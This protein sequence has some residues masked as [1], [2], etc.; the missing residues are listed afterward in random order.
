MNPDVL[1][2]MML[3]GLTTSLARSSAQFNGLLESDAE[4]VRVPG[5]SDLWLAAT[6]DAVVEEI[7]TGLYADP[8]LLG[9][10]TVMV[11]LSDLAAVGAAP[12]GVL[13]A[14]TLK[15][16]MT[17][18][19]IQEMQ[20]GIDG[21]VRACGTHVLGGDTSI[22]D[23]QE[24]CGTALGFVRAEKPL[25]RCGCCAGDIL[26]LSGPAGTGNAFALA[27]FTNTD[28]FPFFPVARVREGQLLPGRASAC[29]DTSDGLLA[30]LDQLCRLNGIGFE[31]DSRWEEALDQASRSAFLGAGLPSWISLAGQHGEFELA[32]TLP[33]GREA[34]FLEQAGSIGWKPKRIGVAT[35]EGGIILPIVGI[36][37]LIDTQAIRDLASRFSGD[38]NGYIAG[39]L[40]A[41]EPVKQRDF[42]PSPPQSSTGT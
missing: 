1:E 2:N 27:R 7:Q 29:M 33:P 26:Y 21:A 36:P 42:G 23:H 40:G 12:A 39:L 20:Q 19:E 6:T 24:M 16:G 17:E 15:R 9:W 34:G 4:L 14:E 10:M 31:I 3:R 38:L 11:N 22:A 8:R 35:V 13:I 25:T 32:F 30:T 41:A 37:H 5:T 28:P 18:K